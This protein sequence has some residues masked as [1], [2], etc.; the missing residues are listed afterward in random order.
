MFDSTWNYL[1]L[2]TYLV[3]CSL[4]PYQLDNFR[5][6]IDPDY[7]LSF[8]AYFCSATT[9][10]RLVDQS[11]SWLKSFLL[12]QVSFFH[13]LTHPRKPSWWKSLKMC[14]VVEVRIYGCKK[15]RQLRWMRVSSVPWSFPQVIFS[16]KFDMLLEVVDHP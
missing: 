16:F 6:T 12:T 4:K 3:K 11:F 7:S 10:P 9:K 8:S 5:P 2:N 15:P 13:W 1:L 14:I